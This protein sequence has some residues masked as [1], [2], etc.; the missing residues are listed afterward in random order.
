[1]RRR[2]LYFPAT[3][4]A[5]QLYIQFTSDILANTAVDSGSVDTTISF[6][7]SFTL[8]ESVETL[9]FASSAASVDT[10]MDYQQRLSVSASAGGEGATLIRRLQ[11]EIESPFILTIAS[12]RV[13]SGGT[14]LSTT[15]E[16][17][18]SDTTFFPFSTQVISISSQSFTG[19][20]NYP[21]GAP[22][23]VP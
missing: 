16:I 23:I 22:I 18:I 3:A 20:Y 13:E 5:V 17:R 10:N 4:E 19:D 6:N 8:L 9:N 15:T 11:I 2:W 21:G 12:T 14:D 1:M 7:K